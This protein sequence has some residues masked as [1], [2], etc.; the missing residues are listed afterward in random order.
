MP[1]EPLV[2]A[3]VEPARTTSGQPRIL[4]TTIVP[5][6]SWEL[7]M[8]ERVSILIAMVLCTS[9][10]LADQHPTQG[11]IVS[12]T[13]VSCGNKDKGKKQSTDLVCQQYTVR[14]NTTEYLIRQEKPAEVEILP[15]N[16]PIEFTVDKDKMK[17]KVNGKKYEFLVVG[18]SAISTKNP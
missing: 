3:T 15:P 1:E 14:T 7:R 10:S 4:F 8:R 18:A 9:L 5:R 2:A 12:E 11:I 17:F 13:S 16:T 6:A